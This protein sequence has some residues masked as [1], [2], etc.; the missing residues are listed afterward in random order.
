MMRDECVE[1]DR[2]QRTVMSI[3]CGEFDELC[4]C[5]FERLEEIVHTIDAAEAELSHELDSVSLARAIE[6]FDGGIGLLGREYTA[7]DSRQV[8]V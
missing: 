8:D 1:R 6:C 5:V 3:A 7:H 2:M 4:K